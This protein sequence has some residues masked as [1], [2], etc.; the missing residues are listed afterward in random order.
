M[1]RSPFLTAALGLALFAC[2]AQET[3]QQATI[4]EPAVDTEAIRT[5]IADGSQRWAAAA[6]A[7]D[8]EAL[9][10][11]YAA[12]AVIYPPDMPSV[13]GR[14]EIRAFF[15][16]MLS[17][18]PVEMTLTTNDVIIGESG[19]MGVELGSFTDASGTG[20]FV[21][22]WKKVDGDWKLAVDT[23]NMTEREETIAE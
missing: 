9:T 1:K 14:E 11:L 19:E 18:G 23:W 10:N 21:A 17:E 20:K 16:Q 15:T 5:T 13:T 6:N 12:D 8:A 22:V 7:G 3:E 2:Q 4:E